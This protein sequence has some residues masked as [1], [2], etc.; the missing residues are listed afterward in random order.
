L[1]LCSDNIVASS[2]GKPRGSESSAGTCGLNDPTIGE[3]SL[4]VLTEEQQLARA[5]ELSLEDRNTSTSLAL[6]VA[7]GNGTAA[8]VG[9]NPGGQCTLGMLPFAT[10]MQIA[11]RRSLANSVQSRKFTDQQLL[12]YV[13]KQSLADVETEQDKALRND[14]INRTLQAQGIQ[15]VNVEVVGDGS[16][17][18]YAYCSTVLNLD[19]LT[20]EETFIDSGAQLRN[21]MCNYLQANRDKV[22]QDGDGE[23]RS[24]LVMFCIEYELDLGEGILPSIYNANYAKWLRTMRLPVTYADQVCVQ[25][26][27]NMMQINIHFMSFLQR[28]VNGVL[29]CSDDYLS[30]YPAYPRVLASDDDI[31]LVNR[32]PDHFTA[33]HK[34]PIP[35]AASVVASSSSTVPST[36]VLPSAGK[37]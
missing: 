13:M 6:E 12:A 22:A 5:I 26:V 34:P 21:T 32:F 20:T 15:R 11:L 3:D 2:G 1:R 37:C 4:G 19:E 18:F 17:F 16:C 24:F 14:F 10:Q 27:A 35:P 8:G 36:V 23:R 30:W 29:R 33:T 31:F 7:L 9:V 28:K 25:A